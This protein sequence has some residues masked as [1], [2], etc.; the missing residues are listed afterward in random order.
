MDRIPIDVQYII[1]S[2]LPVEDLMRC[3]YVNKQ[4]AEWFRSNIFK[5]AQRTIK[6][7]IPILW[8]IL[9]TVTCRYDVYGNALTELFGNRIPTVNMNLVVTIQKASDLLCVHNALSE[10][11]VKSPSSGYQGWG[12][13]FRIPAFVNKKVYV[14]F[15]QEGGVFHNN[16]NK[17]VHYILRQYHL[18]SQLKLGF[19][20]KF[21]M[22]I[23]ISYPSLIAQ[24]ESNKESGINSLIV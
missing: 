9:Q 3:K 17:S 19:N 16:I 18:T 6:T 7:R 14:Y 13:T 2:F 22:E 1:L 23:A 4:F 5:C 24:I 10:I 12:F 20:N 15:I 8:N 11:L 21:Y